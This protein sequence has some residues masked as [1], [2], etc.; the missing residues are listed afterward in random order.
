M[1]RIV[2]LPQPDGPTMET[3]SPCWHVERDIVHRRDVRAGVGIEVRLR[4][5]AD[6]QSV[7][8]ESPI[9]SAVR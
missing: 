6:G 2:V 3:N 1:L 9:P 5:I 4:Q 7:F 8:I